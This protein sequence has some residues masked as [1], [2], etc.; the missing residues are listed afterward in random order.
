MGACVVDPRYSA[1][2]YRGAEYAFSFFTTI[3]LFPSVL[4]REL[5]RIASVPTY[6]YVVLWAD[7]RAVYRDGVCVTLIRAAAAHLAHTRARRMDGR[8]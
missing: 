5:L 3:H 1:S 8:R 4:F 6:R 2:K 7:A